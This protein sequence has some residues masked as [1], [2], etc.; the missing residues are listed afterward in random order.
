MYVV[1]IQRNFNAFSCDLDSQRCEFRAVYLKISIRTSLLIAYHVPNTIIGSEG[2]R[3]RRINVILVL[4]PG[5]L[6]TYKESS[7][8]CVS[9]EKW[10]SK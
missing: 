5:S 10:G 6:V 7:K 9:S 1:R 8:F 2:E 4:N 3:E